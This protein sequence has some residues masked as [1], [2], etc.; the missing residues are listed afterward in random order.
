MAKG[1]ILVLGIGNPLFGD[2]GVGPRVVQNLARRTR[3]PGLDFLDGGT[4][5]PHLLG[6]LEGYSHLV[7]VDALDAGLAPGTICR[8]TPG[9]ISSRGGKLSFHQTGLDDLLALARLAGRLPETVILGIQIERLGWG[10]DLSP[11]VAV[12]LPMLEELVLKEVEGIL[13][14][15]EK[16]HPRAPRG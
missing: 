10:T 8:L 1:K 11:A 15:L 4:A 7:V 12:R 6:Y 9:E 16:L 3:R 13:R 2:D 14:R 5:G